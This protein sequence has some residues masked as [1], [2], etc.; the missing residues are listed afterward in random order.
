MESLT[1]T[2]SFRSSPRSTAPAGKGD[3]TA[4]APLT[5]AGRARA[6]SEGVD[7]E[8]KAFDGS[9]LGGRPEATSLPAAGFAGSFPG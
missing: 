8:A 5:G 4:Q 6:G 9:M 7:Q 3:G 2:P 1:G